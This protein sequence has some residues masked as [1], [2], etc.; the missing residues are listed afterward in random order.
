MQCAE[1]MIPEL[2]Y[3]AII[4]SL[5][6]NRR[7]YNDPIIISFIAIAV[8]LL[9]ASLWEIFSGSLFSLSSSAKMIEHYAIL[10]LR[11]VVLVALV[12]VVGKDSLVSAKSQKETV[13][14]ARNQFENKGFWVLYNK[15][16]IVQHGDL[17]RLTQKSVTASGRF[18]VDLWGTSCK[19][20]G[21]EAVLLMRG[22]PQARGASTIIKLEFDD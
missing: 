3:G 22:Q 19:R 10:S 12:V 9:A 2:I 17:R 11:V 21:V 16:S 1:N 20:T 15:P 14:R 4:A 13:T 7:T 18:L 8:V 6:I 5:I